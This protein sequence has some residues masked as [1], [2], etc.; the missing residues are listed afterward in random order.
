MVNRRKNMIAQQT[1]VEDVKLLNE[2]CFVTDATFFEAVMAD[3]FGF[4]PLF[5]VGAVAVI[6]PTVRAG[7]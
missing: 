6:E 2:S 1:P 4:E 5:G 7:A 3:K